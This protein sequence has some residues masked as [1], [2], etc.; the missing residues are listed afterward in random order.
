MIAYYNCEQGFGE[1]ECSS[2]LE[3]RES[4]DELSLEEYVSCCHLRII[5]TSIFLPV[6]SQY[7]YKVLPLWSGVQTS[8]TTLK[9]YTHFLPIGLIL[10]HF[11]WIVLNTV[12]PI[13]RLRVYSPY[14][15]VVTH[16]YN[17]GEPLYLVYDLKIIRTDQLYRTIWIYCFGVLMPLLGSE[18]LGHVR[19]A[20]NKT[21]IS[22]ERHLVFTSRFMNKSIHSKDMAVIWC[23]A[24]APPPTF[25]PIWFLMY[26][27]DE[28]WVTI[29]L[30]SSYLDIG[31]GTKLKIKRQ[32]NNNG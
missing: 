2:L 7:I 30:F 29:E 20:R 10:W 8:L 23:I 21:K 15:D 6:E 17:I 16:K 12:R 22:F 25:F 32:I 11:K 24:G 18:Q 1:A 19:Q 3:L 26:Q 9:I 4:S 5:L 14:D 28:N 27:L 13:I 31:H